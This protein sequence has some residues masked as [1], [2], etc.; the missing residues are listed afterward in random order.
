MTSVDE[1]GVHINRG[2]LDTIP[3]SWTSG[4]RL[5]RISVTSRQYDN[6]VRADGEAVTYR[7][8]PQTSVDTLDYADAPDE[9]ITPSDRAMRPLRPADV[10]V[11]SR[12]WGP[13]GTE[14]DTDLTITWSNRNRIVE[15]SVALP[16]TAASSGLED[17]QTTTVEVL[18]A[19]GAVLATY[20][21]LTG[22]SLTIPITDFG[23]ET[24]GRIRVAS[25]RDGYTSLQAYEIEV[26]PGATIAYGYGGS[27]GAYYGG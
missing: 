7:L 4:T 21:G 14:S 9:I 11:R 20:S 5:W 15:A 3:H 6:T 22:S 8:L 1:D 26:W 24:V 2:L 18:A 13:V 10:R 19:G 16:W 25:E 27:Y 17:G 12:Q 23:A